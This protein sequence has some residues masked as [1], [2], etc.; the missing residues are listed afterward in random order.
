MQN[1]AKALKDAT[2]IAS[3]K[4]VQTGPVSGRL[5]A[6]ASKVGMADDSFVDMNQRLQT[7]SNIMLKLRSGAA[8]TESEYQRFIK[9]YPQPND[10]KEVRERKAKNS[11]RYMNELIDDKVTAFGE[12]GYK[13]PNIKPVEVP[14]EQPGALPPE[15]VSKLQAGK[16]T[17]FKNGQKWTLGQNGQ[18]Q[19]VQ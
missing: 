14:G 2:D 12:S 9:E 18:P 10:P 1:V 13:T 3:K 17:A 7:A 4:K 15:A 11:I 19:R 5:Q 16:I 8:V 6:L